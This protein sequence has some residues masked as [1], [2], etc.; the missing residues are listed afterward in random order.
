MGNCTAT[1]GDILPEYAGMSRQ[2]IIDQER[3]YV[4]EFRRHLDL[5]YYRP[6]GECGRWDPAYACDCQRVFL[7]IEELLDHLGV[8]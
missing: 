6:V 3:E 7:H 1:I 4:D 5:K 8:T 2:A